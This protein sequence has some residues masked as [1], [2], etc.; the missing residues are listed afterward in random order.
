MLDLM[1]RSDESLKWKKRNADMGPFPL[2]RTFPFLLLPLL[3]LPLKT[4]M[5][6][7]KV[8]KN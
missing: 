4:E 8:Y 2:L 3:S 7:R 1:Y 6:S 5:N